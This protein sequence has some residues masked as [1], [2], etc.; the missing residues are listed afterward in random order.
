MYEYRYMFGKKKQ[1]SKTV[2][3]IDAST[4]QYV[5]ILKIIPS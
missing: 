2:V 5:P 3:G 4:C 1:D